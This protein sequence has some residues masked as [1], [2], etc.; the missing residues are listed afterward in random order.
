MCLLVYCTHQIIYTKTHLIKTLRPV[1]KL[2][3]FTVGP[4]EG[5]KYSLEMQKKKEMGVRQKTSA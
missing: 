4:K 3:E 5:S 1:E 2:Q